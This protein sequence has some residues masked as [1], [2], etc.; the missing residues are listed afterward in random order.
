MER[1]IP[2][3]ASTQFDAAA[4]EETLRSAGIRSVL[5]PTWERFR[6]AVPN[7][8][9]GVVVAPWLDQ[10]PLVR[11]QDFATDLPWYPLLL[12]TERPPE[13]LRLLARIRVEAVLFLN[14]EEH[15]LPDLIRTTQ[16]GA[17]F[18]GLARRI[19]N[20]TTLPQ[21]LRV[22]LARLLEEEPPAGPVDASSPRAPPRSIRSLARRVRCSPDYLGRLARKHGIDLRSFLGWV[23]ALR[24]LQLRGNGE[25]TWERIAWSLGYESVSGLSEHLKSTLGRRP[26]E[27]DHGELAGWFETMQERFNLLGEVDRSSR[28]SVGNSEGRVL[29]KIGSSTNQGH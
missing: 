11:I 21:M 18:L 8:E 12:L 16:G 19:R 20:R 26:S 4:V 17:L 28:R 27:L 3:S 22:V 7:T 2:I 25:M 6:S 14:A 1:P 24:A 10:Y 13:N 5:C 9:V 15:L 29:E 23:M